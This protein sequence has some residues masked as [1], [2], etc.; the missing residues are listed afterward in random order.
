MR[1][2]AVEVRGSTRELM[3]EAHAGFPS[4]GGGKRAIA[5]RALLA[6][7]LW[8]A[9]GDRKLPTQ[10]ELDVALSSVSEADLEWTCE[11]SALGPLYLLPTRPFIQRLAS[12]LRALSVRRVLEVAAGDGFLSR[13]LAAAAPELEVTACDSGAW[14]TPEARMSAKE[15]RALRGVDVPGLRLGPHVIKCSAAHAIARF[16]PALVLCS[17]LPP[18][19]LL[20]GLVRQNV[21]Y[22]LE[23]GAEHG[24]TASPYSWRFA[25]EFLEGP[26]EARARCRLDTR[27]KEKLHSRLTLYYGKA[28]PEHY[29]ERV[30]KNDWLYQFRPKKASR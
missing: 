2:Q 26:L 11:F 29:E 5:G 1:E 12:Q 17:W 21:R 16:E 20:D 28:H 23:I 14:Q 10:S 24:V 19:H 6:R 13:A 22:V 7:A 27:P 8:N 4:R 30:G 25:H 9:R 15:R 3:I 18:G